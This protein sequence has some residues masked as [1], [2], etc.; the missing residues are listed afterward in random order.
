MLREPGRGAERR[1]SLPLWRL[2]E[3]IDLSILSGLP[4]WQDAVLVNSQYSLASKRKQVPDLGGEDS[5]QPIWTS[6]IEDWTANPRLSPRDNTLRT[7]QLAIAEWHPCSDRN[8]WELRPGTKGCSVSLAKRPLY[9]G[10]I[11][12]MYGAIKWVYLIAIGIFELG[13]LV[14]GVAPN[15]TAMIAGRAVPGNS[16]E[17]N[18]IQ[19]P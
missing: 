7:K 13:S 11:G 18:I 19:A 10:G 14:C 4:E 15:S 16:V 3:Q 2:E 6:T 5:S 17:E 9:T 8:P 1:M 12:A